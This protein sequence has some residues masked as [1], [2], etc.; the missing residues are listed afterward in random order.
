[1]VVGDRGALLVFNDA[2]ERIFGRPEGRLGPER[3]PE[4]FG[5]FLPDGVTPHPVDDLPLVRAM[6]GEER[7]E[8]EV[9]VR[10]ARSPQGRRLRVSAFPW[11]DA[12]GRRLGAIAVFRDVTAHQ[13]AE[14]EL[15]NLSNAVEVAADAIY[16][17]DLHGVIE[18][19]NAGFEAIT[20]YSRDEVIGRSPRVLRSGTHEREHYRELWDTL[21]AGRVHRGT[22]VNQ[23]KD[24]TVYHAEMTITPIHAPGGAITHF[25][26]VGKDMT[27][28]RLRQEHELELGLA[29]SVQRELFPAG[30]PSFAGLDVAGAAHPA[31]AMCG[32]FY[33]YVPIG[34]D[35]LALAIGDVSGH[36]LGPALVMAE[37]RAYLR[38][39]LGLLPDVGEVLRMLNRML[40]R[41]LVPG[42]FV[43]MLLVELD[44]RT[45]TLTWAS[46]GHPTGYLLD[47]A[48]AVRG[49]LESTGPPLGI[50]NAWEAP[51]SVPAALVPGDLLVLVTDGVTESA[52]P[53]GSLLDGRG[54]LELI[55]RHRSGSARQVL[56]GIVGGVREFVHDS[57]QADDM[58]AVVCRY[59]P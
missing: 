40:A 24:G 33:D 18:Y 52:A 15:R 29:R 53:D 50:S 39:Y 38:A 42:S 1:M 37:T 30:P 6:R 45:R 56:D 35:R 57:P 51:Q 48:G 46:A 21:L 31:T 4:A 19:V 44:L 17:T 10:N 2:A 41:D 5:L 32:D 25:V 55:R 26:A 27:E 14:G 34:A 47:A 23:R 54:V 49:A 59:Q 20:G 43:T 8:V 22:M 58:T 7:R 12:S 36:G 9:H 16:I 13:L 28:R 3:W 11:R